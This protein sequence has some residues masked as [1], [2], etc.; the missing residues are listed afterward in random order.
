MKFLGPSWKTTVIGFVAA[1]AS[2]LASMGVNL[3][4]DRDGWTSAIISASLFALGATAKDSNVTNSPIPVEAKPFEAK[5]AT[6]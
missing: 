1:V 4:T 3:P 2:Y 5:P 6:P